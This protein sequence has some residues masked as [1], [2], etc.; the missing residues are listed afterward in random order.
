MAMLTERPEL[1]A[2][3]ADAVAALIDDA[4]CTRERAVALAEAAAT[5]AVQDALATIAGAE[6]VY[7]SIVDVRL[8]RLR[9]I[10]EA[11]GA[12]VA[13]PTAY[14]TGAIFRITSSQGRTLLRTYQ[15]RHAKDYRGRMTS[16]VQPVARAAEAVGR[17]SRFEFRFADA[18]TLE[19]AAD[20]L[21]R[22]GFER[23]LKTDR[24]E[25]LLTVDTAVKVAG[26]DAKQFLSA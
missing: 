19:Y 10:I 5:A 16:A 24:P 18:G 13:P 11:L 22:H 21:R 1:E 9:R 17:P 2:S 26:K 20:R 15:A 6:P 25:L 12:G 8:A 7:G 4:G 3:A 14:E 23:T